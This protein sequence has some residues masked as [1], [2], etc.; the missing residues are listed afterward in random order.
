MCVSRPARRAVEAQDQDYAPLWQAQVITARK[1]RI[2]PG[3]CT[4]F[5]TG[6]MRQE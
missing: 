3:F 2:R 1:D 4:G 5:C 6:M